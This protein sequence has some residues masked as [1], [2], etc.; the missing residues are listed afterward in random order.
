M[1]NAPVTIPHINL[2][3]LTFE[4]GK[5]LESR[6]DAFSAKLMSYNVSKLHVE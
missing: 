4:R 5:P 1:I 2:M 3:L 6:N